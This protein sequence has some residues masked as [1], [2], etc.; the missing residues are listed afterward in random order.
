MAKN[1]T[2]VIPSQFALKR[3]I[4]TSPASFFGVNA[5]GEERKIKAIQQMS[6]GVVSNYLANDADNI[7]SPNPQTTQYCLLNDDENILRIKF[8]IKFL[9]LC[10]KSISFC[11][12]EFF[13]MLA[14][15]RSEYVSRNGFAELSH[16]YVS[17]LIN[18]RWTF[19]NGDCGIHSVTIKEMDWTKV[20]KEYVFDNDFITKNQKSLETFT[21]TSTEMKEIEDKITNVF[22]AKSSTVVFNVSCDIHLYGGHEVFPS[23]LCTMDADNSKNNK[24]VCKKQLYQFSDGVAFRMEKIGN[25]IRTID[26]WYN[27]FDDFFCEV[28]PVN[29]YSQSRSM[30][31]ALRK[32]ST[33]TDFYSLLERSVQNPETA[34]DNDLHFIF[35]GFI[36]GGVYG[37]KA[38]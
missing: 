26:S 29:P 9:P 8:N 11:T 22:N 19:R 1:N 36:R 17:N 35:A 10:K 18:G 25:A 7:S 2:S 33:K 20:V 21:C 32:P 37:V 34:S 31:C 24:D 5:N 14:E 27:G 13:K 3:L 12:P 23:E 4:E 38:K 15:L 28:L 30:L 16:R 6:L